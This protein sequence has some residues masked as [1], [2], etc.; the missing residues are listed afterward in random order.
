MDG[1]KNLYAVLGLPPD[2]TSEDVRKAYRVM[3]RRFHPDVNHNEGAGLQFRDISAAHEILGEPSQRVRYDTYRQQYEDESAHFTLR[4]TPSKRVL[5]ALPEPQVFYLLVEIVPL[6]RSAKRAKRE[7]PLNLTLVLD[8]STSM[9]GVRLEKVK[10]AARQIIEQLTPNDILSVVTFSDRAEVLIPANKVTNPAALQAAIS[11]IRAKGGT[12]MFYA[13]EAGLQECRRHSGPRLVNHIILLTDGRTYGDEDP[14]RELAA[15]AAEEGIGISAMGIGEEW[16]DEFLDD[17]AT[18][19]GGTS[20]YINSPTAV[21]KFLNDRVRSLGDVYVDRMQLSIAPDADVEL[22]SAFKL[23]P[24]PQPLEVSP[25]PIPLGALEFSRTSSVLLQLQ[26][27]PSTKSGFRTV[28]RLDVTGDVIPSR[29][30][31]YK[32]LSD[33][34]VEIAHDPEP[35]EP[36]MAVMD[37]LGKL[38]LYRMQQK[39]EQAL[40]KG[41]VIEATRRLENLA[42]R[43]LA[44]G[45]EDL[46]QMAMSEANRVSKTNALSE[47][48]R[49]TLKFGTRKLLGLPQPGGNGDDDQSG[50]G[51]Q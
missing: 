12:E 26:M 50:D 25:Q 45:Q 33:I 17:I 15:Q 13:L 37:A 41:D 39:A 43:L 32:V 31:G 5:T 49:M 44:A 38:T 2:A 29:R 47:Q 28:V 24:S 19:T 22:E 16:N 11:I 10:I 9:R 18:A 3:A 51:D 21:V 30:Q 46:A 48:G 35:Q 40:A 1:S 23:L 6:R 34:S 36:P 7:V 4:V 20:G 42:T 14:S 8:R 27:P